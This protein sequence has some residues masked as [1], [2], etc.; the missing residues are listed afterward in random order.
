[1]PIIETVD[2]VVSG[3]VSVSDAIR[4]LMSRD[5]KSELSGTSFDNRY[6]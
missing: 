6:D 1:M 4:T 3:R 2:A 5:L